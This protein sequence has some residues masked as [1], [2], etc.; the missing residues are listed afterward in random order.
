MI[1]RVF[2]GL[3]LACLLIPSIAAESQQKSANRAVIMK[4]E[5]LSQ[6]EAA[7]IVI[8]RPTSAGTQDFIIVDDETQPEDLA[9][10]VGALLFS[11]RSQG[12]TVTRELR[13]NVAPAPRRTTK[14]TRDEIT[15]TRDLAR[16]RG[17]PVVSVPGIGTGRVLQV[18]TAAVKPRK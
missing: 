14:K 4:V 12:A 3:A 16:L 6:P 7:A 2:R 11:R 17:A 1:V 10:A 15:A 8:R 5:K 9:R 18:A 13:A